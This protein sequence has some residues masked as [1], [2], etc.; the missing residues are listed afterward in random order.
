MCKVMDRVYRKEEMFGW[1][2]QWQRDL[3]TEI[4][5]LEWQECQDAFS[6]VRLSNEKAKWK[7]MGGDTGVF[8]V[9]VIKKMMDTDRGGGTRVEFKWCK[10][11]TLKCNIML[12]RANLDRLATRVNLRRRNVI[13]LSDLCLMCEEIEET[14]EHLFT[15]CMFANRVWIS[16]SS[17][18]KIPSL[19]V[20]SVKDLME[21]H[22]YLQMG[23][24]AKK[25]IDGLI[26][27]TVWCIWK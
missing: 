24:K 15:A 12:W 3:E 9:K 25:I 27:I 16:F 18:F 2:W 11:V 14:M 19:F 10:W 5:W 17:W 23:K 20:F 4:E 26:I 1:A 7:W 21:L 13:I 22:R 8:T 6:E